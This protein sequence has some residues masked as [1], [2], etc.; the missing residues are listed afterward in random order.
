[1]LQLTI[2]TL[3]LIDNA[4][5]PDR[6]DSDAGNALAPIAMVWR[7]PSPIWRNRRRFEEAVAD[8]KK[9]IADNHNPNLIEPIRDG[10]SN[11]CRYEPI[12]DSFEVVIA[13][14]HK[15]NLFKPIRDDSG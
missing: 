1:M 6:D 14:N 11:Q 15:P 3:Q 5:A 10:S 9:A 12:R 2:M 13:E 7:N 8:L 4:S